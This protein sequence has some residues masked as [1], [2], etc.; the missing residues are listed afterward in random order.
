MQRDIC[1]DGVARHR[2]S[3]RGLRP[4]SAYVGVAFAYHGDIGNGVT[5]AALATAA[6]R[7]G[8][9]VLPRQRATR[10]LPRL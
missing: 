10:I 4:S 5:A 3:V 8:M 9:Y 2:A 6:A 7:V 1:I